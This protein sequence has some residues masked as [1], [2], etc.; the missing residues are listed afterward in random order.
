[1]SNFTFGPLSLTIAKVQTTASLAEIAAI[2]SNKRPS[3]AGLVSGWG[4]VLDDLDPLGNF[5]PPP[6]VGD[7]LIEPATE[8]YPERLMAR[9]YFWTPDSGARRSLST[10]A[11]PS[12]AYRL[13]SCDLLVSRIDDD[14]CLIGVSSRTADHLTTHIVPSLRSVFTGADQNAL[15][16]MDSSPLD[17]LDADVFLWL[18]NRSASN[19]Q[20]HAGLNMIHIRE[21]TSQDVLSRG[22]NLSHGVDLSRRELLALITNQTTRFGPAK[23]AVEYEAV[24]AYLDFELFIDGGFTLHATPSRYAQPMGRE[25]KG[26]R[27][28]PDLVYGVIPL[29][30]A[31]YDADG[32]W[33]AT[34]RET[35][36]ALCMSRLQGA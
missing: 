34:D 33:D 19:P 7:P 4:S 15:L 25:A 24:N 21:I 20:L 8:V 2:I 26:M 36:K 18:V 30:K 6:T 9:F 1:M 32:S 10:G 12:R 31:G 5:G 3:H 28:V 35:F 14:S 11:D 29:L 17:L 16:Q 22:A 23:I 27:A 13:R